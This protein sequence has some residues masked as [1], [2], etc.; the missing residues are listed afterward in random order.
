MKS[1]KVVAKS[2]MKIVLEGEDNTLNDVVVT[3]LGVSR[4]KKALG[5]A[6]T[7]LKGDE[8]LKSR[9]CEMHRGFFLLFSENNQQNV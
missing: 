7:E 6:V 2:K 3:A 1:Q 9:G 4:Q 5:Y 8:M